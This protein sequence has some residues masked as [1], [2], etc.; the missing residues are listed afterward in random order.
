M[1]PLLH[2][3]YL[4]CGLSLWSGVSFTEN[5]SPRTLFHFLHQNLRSIY[6]QT[7]VRFPRI[8]MKFILWKKKS[9]EPRLLTPF[10]IFLHK[11]D[12]YERPTRSIKI[13]LLARLNRVLQI[14]LINYDLPGTL[15][16]NV[17]LNPKIPF[18]NWPMQ[19]Q[20]SHTASLA[21]GPFPLQ[22]AR[23]APVRTDHLASLQ[24]HVGKPP[25]PQRVNIWSKQDSGGLVAQ[26]VLVF[27]MQ[28]HSDPEPA[29]T[30]RRLL[31]Y[32]K[33][34]RIWIS[35]TF[36]CSLYMLCVHV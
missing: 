22:V 31:H 10:I 2:V 19:C 18:V 9:M 24:I 13:V 26:R 6:F 29:G 28:K 33:K 35:L 21:G 4:V 12:P 7:P 5:R 16:T 8:S 34:L 25:T 14:R 20:I 17:K 32:T 23:T 3:M 36:L 11:R 27:C 1:A 30:L 15:T